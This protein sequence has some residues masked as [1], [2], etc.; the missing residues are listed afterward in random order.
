[1]TAYLSL[2]LS[3]LLK[4]CSLYFLII[5]LFALK[6]PRP[7]ERHAPKTRFACLIPAR[8]EQ[9]VIA[10][11]VDSLKAQSY[12]AE[13]FDIYVIPNNCTDDTEGAARRAGAR[14]FRCRGAVRCKGDALHEAV[15]WLLPQGYGAFCVFDADNLAH[16]D[17]LARMND[18][19]C[20][21]ARAAKGRMAAKNPYDSWVSG[22]YGLHFTLFDTFFSR[23]RMNCGLSSKLV[24]TGFA[25]ESGLL[26][27]MGGWNTVT[28]AEDA[29]F[30]A[31]CAR[32]GVRICFVPDALTYDEAPRSLRL[33]LRQ[34]RRWCSGIMDVSDRYSGR[35]LPA[36][37]R[38]NRFA[39]DSFMSLTSPFVQALSSV[40]PVLAGA[41]VIA[42]DVPV[43]LL[44]TAALLAALGC[45]ACAG[46]GLVLSLIG[47]YRDRRIIK[48]AALFPVFMATWLPLQVLSALCRSKSWKPIAH[49]G[50]SAAGLMEQRRFSRF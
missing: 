30:S 5:A 11:L 23:A 35:L 39:F 32:R 8:N 19:L 22:C 47:G 6:R 27:E 3:L 26:R 10:G 45:L 37:V 17:F 41:A 25:V 44:L 34:R 36:A 48:S 42:G 49:G 18:A 13:L 20:S 38:G 21:G 7:F 14:I 24:G 43:P 4:V 46:F 16:P 1:M 33:S 50:V 2:G 29:E 12:P 28:M 9:A 15:S 40:P 31:Q